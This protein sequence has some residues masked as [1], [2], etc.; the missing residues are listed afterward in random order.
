MSCFILEIELD[1]LLYMMHCGA[2]VCMKTF[3]GACFGF[4]K[5]VLNTVNRFGIICWVGCRK[6]VREAICLVVAA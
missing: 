3:G 2:A 1:L 4:V 6:E 5:C